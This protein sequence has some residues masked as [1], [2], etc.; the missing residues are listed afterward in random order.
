MRYKYPPGIAQENYNLTFVDK[1]KHFFIFEGA[2]DSFFI[3]NSLACGGAS[4]LKTL[5][6]II[7]K[8]YYKNLVLF[9]DGDKDGIQTSY[10]ALRSGYSVFVW[11]AEMMELRDKVKNKIDLNQLVMSGYCDQI[12]DELGQ[13]PYDYIMKHVMKP[14]LQNLIAF[15]MHYTKYGFEMEEKKDDWSVQRTRKNTN[16]RPDRK[17]WK[18]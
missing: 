12:I 13:I 9:F 14:T 3:D 10:A 4:K 16:N 15:E 8:K 1:N 11:S 6:S 17:S 2:I 5:L 7:D 18:W